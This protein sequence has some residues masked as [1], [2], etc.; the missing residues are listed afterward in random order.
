MKGLFELE[1]KKV[2]ILLIFDCCF[3]LF[4]MVH[5]MFD[6]KGIK[7]QG[8]N[9]DKKILATAVIPQ[10]SFESYECRKPE[11]N[12]RFDFSSVVVA[13][14]NHLKKLGGRCMKIRVT[15]IDSWRV[16]I[17]F[18]SND[19]VSYEVISSYMYKLSDQPEIDS[20]ISFEG[21]T[22]VKKCL[23]EVDK[24][25]EVSVKDG[26]ATFKGEIMRMSTF[27]IG[28]PGE[29]YCKIPVK[30]LK[31][32]NKFL[33]TTINNSEIEFC[34]REENLLFSVDKEHY[35]IDIRLTTTKALGPC[36]GEV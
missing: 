8:S 7:I 18:E 11:E 16:R 36:S 22:T 30:R 2:H 1:L 9:K 26:I 31:L 25:V 15:N 32:L 19:G 5:M 10:D 20:G 6:S 24:D 14:P 13:I 21:Y 23:V 29:P 33:G 34:K 17:T 12:S 3:R 27:I 4:P 28:E 35:R